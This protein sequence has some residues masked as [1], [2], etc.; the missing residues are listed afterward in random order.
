MRHARIPLFGNSMVAMDRTFRRDVRT[1]PPLSRNTP[2]HGSLPTSKA[3]TDDV[4][5]GRVLRDGRGRRRA[6]LPGDRLRL[7]K[8]GRDRFRAESAAVERRCAPAAPVPNSRYIRQH[9]PDS[10]SPLAQVL[11]ALGHRFS[12]EALLIAETIGVS[13]LMTQLP[14][15]ESILFRKNVRPVRI[16]G[17]IFYFRWPTQLQQRHAS[18]LRRHL[19]IFR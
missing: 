11:P 5:A 16:S 10:Q 19:L 14:A 15:M 1:H 13:D 17:G 9:A 8:L 6:S 4:V 3:M 2:P 18:V 7:D 12:R